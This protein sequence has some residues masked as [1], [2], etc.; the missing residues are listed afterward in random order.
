[1][2]LQP[3][4]HIIKKAI[5]FHETK[6]IRH[7]AMLIGQTQKGK[8]TVSRVVAKALE[9]QSIKVK[10]CKLNSYSVSYDGLYGKTVNNEWKDGMLTRCMREMQKHG[11]AILDQQ[12]WISNAGSAILDHL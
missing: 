1:M 9:L 6:N 5:Q 4:K 2:N 7:G 8:N 3:T 11:S 10:M 12:C